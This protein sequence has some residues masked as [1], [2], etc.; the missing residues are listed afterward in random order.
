M[1]HESVIGSKVNELGIEEDRIKIFYIAEQIIE[2]ESK[3]LGII[4]I[5]IFIENEDRITIDI[6][7]KMC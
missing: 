2:R 6:A 1:R 5:C 4:I 7:G 3:L